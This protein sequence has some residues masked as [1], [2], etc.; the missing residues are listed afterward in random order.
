MA[1]VSVDFVSG[2]FDLDLYRFFSSLITLEIEPVFVDWPA[3][4]FSRL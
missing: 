3:Q 2:D 1:N 4:C